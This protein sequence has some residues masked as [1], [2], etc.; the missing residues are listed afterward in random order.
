[1]LAIWTEDLNHF[2]LL[3]FITTIHHK[4]KALYKEGKEKEHKRTEC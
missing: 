3:I 2:N 4:A 1:M